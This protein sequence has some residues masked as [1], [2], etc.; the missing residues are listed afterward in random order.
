MTAAS[1][2]AALAWALPSNVSV[3][4]P[5]DRGLTWNTAHAFPREPRKEGSR[6]EMY[7]RC[8]FQRYGVVGK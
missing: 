3:C 4:G 5:A 8:R 7:P 2:Q 6:S 1:Q